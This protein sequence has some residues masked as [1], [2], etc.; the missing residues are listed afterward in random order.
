MGSRCPE[1]AAGASAG[2]GEGGAGVAA[3][4]GSSQMARTDWV[5][6]CTPTMDSRF[7]LR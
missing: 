3:D 5:A 2:E 6:A 4:P 1:R 7:S